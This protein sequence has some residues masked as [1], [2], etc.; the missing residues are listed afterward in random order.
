MGT[1]KY[2]QNDQEN[3]F[4]SILVFKKDF[5]QMNERQLRNLLTEVD[6]LKNCIENKLEYLDWFGKLPK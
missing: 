5:D 1:G 6:S 2:Y 3:Q 4:H